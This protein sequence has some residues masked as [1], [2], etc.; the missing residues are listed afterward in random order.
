V[1]RVVSTVLFVVGYW[2]MACLDAQ[3]A[4]LPAVGSFAAAS[5][6]IVKPV[7]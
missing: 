7:L 1:R 4:F 3:V 2:L 5:A 6:L